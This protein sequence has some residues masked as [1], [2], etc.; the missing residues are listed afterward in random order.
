MRH[1]R[2]RHLHDG[3]RATVVPCDNAPDN[4]SITVY[5]RSYTPIFFIP[6]YY[7]KSNGYPLEGKGV[8]RCEFK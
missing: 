4:T 1:Q 6:P 3:V 5:A 2:Q 8:Y 7:F